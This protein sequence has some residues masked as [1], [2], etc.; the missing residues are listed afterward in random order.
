MEY[1]GFVVEAFERDPGKWRAKICRSSG[2]PLI[3]MSRKRILQFVTGIDATSASAALVMALEA[4]NARAFSRAPPLP[5]KFWCH[6]G[7]GE[8]SSG[9]ALGEHR[10][11]TKK[12]PRK[13][14]GHTGPKDCYG[15]TMSNKSART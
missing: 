4:I 12:R 6:N 3:I 10:S 11:R 15:R 7:H 1:Q 14:G 5:E 9:R 2:M 8:N 13:P